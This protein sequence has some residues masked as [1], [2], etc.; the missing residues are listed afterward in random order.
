VVSKKTALVPLKTALFSMN[1]AQAT[2]FV[3][4]DDYHE[5][6]AEDNSRFNPDAEGGSGAPFL[7]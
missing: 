5:A 4:A 6:T 7:N 1:V 2:A 3:P